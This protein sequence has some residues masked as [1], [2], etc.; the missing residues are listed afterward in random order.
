M[1]P[2][3]LYLMAHCY[4]HLQPLSSTIC[5]FLSIPMFLASL[6]PPPPLNFT[7]KRVSLD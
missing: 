5:H 4:T 6:W 7:K 2:L 1:P 3:S